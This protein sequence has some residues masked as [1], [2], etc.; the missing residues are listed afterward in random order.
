MPPPSPEPPQEQ[1]TLSDGELVLRPWAT[2]DAGPTR[3]LHDD[4]TAYWFDFPSSIPTLEGQLAWIATTRDQWDDDR[5]KVTFAVETGGEIVGS[6]DVRRRVPGVGVLSWMTFSQHRG[7][8]IASRATRLLVE[9]AF[10]SD[11]LGLRRVE[12]EV[13]PLNTASVRTALRSGLRR[14][15]LLRGNTTLGDTVHDTAV[16]GRLVDDPKPGTREGFTAMLNSQ[17]PTK[18]VIA[19][20]LIRNSAGAILLCELAYKRDWDLPGGVV[21]PGESPAAC[22]VREIREELDVEVELTG[23]LAVNWLAP[24]LGWDDAVLFV[25]E[26]APVGDDVLSRAHLLERELK[27]AHWVTVTDAAAHV[28]PYNERMLASLVAAGILD[29]PRAHTAASP[30]VASPTIASTTTTAHHATLLL[31]DGVAVTVRE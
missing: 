7:Q 2:A 11:G 17:L 3:L 22:L 8:G 24:Y 6:V 18:R 27:G 23:L 1:P 16:F 4:V 13:N 31:E 12:A 20:G 29:S 28:A 10:S 19:Q 21:D 25:F 30:M 15:G 14:E 26:V 9:W 5:S